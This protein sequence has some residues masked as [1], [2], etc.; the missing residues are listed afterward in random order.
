M[1]QA[2][3]IKLRKMTDILDPKL[4]YFKNGTPAWQGKCAESGSTIQRMLN[5]EERASLKDQQLNKETQDN[6]KETQGG[7]TNNAKQT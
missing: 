2:Y 7:E 5:K 3:N 4:V 1:V 6:T